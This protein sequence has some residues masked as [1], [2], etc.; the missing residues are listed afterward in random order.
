VALLSKAMGRDLFGWFSE[1][2]MKAE[3]AKA[4]VR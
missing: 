1:H 2:G 3:R 4:Q